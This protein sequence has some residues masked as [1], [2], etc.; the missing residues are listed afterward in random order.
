MN[1]SGKW[2]RDLCDLVKRR[3]RACVAA[4]RRCLPFPLPYGAVHVHHIRHRGGC[5][6]MDREEN[7]ISLDPYIHAE[8]HG[9][10]EAEYRNYIYTYMES[11]DVPTVAFRRSADSTGLI[12][13]GAGIETPVTPEE[14]APEETFLHHQVVCPKAKRGIDPTLCTKCPYWENGAGL[15][16]CTYRRISN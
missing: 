8:L 3:D 14:A 10:R 2:Y 16:A 7:L 9:G 1:R 13:H 11:K 15:W 5:A 4:Y 6:S 12:F